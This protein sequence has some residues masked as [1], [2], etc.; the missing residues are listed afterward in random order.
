MPG[1]AR[2]G[3]VGRFYRRGMVPPSGSSSG[4]SSD[5]SGSGRPAWHGQRLQLE[6][7]DINIGPDDGVVESPTDDD[8]EQIIR[9][10]HSADTGFVILSRGDLHYMQT[11]RTDAEDGDLIVEYQDGDTSRHYL[12]QHTTNDPD[13]VLGLFRLWRDDPAQ[14]HG[15]AEWQLLLDL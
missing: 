11:A 8:L 7:A 4:S 2:D 12:L 3:T 13:E 1:G 10:L 5:S 6:W 15:A 14:V 9:Q